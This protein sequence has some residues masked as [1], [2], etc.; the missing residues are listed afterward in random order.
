M[1]NILFLVIAL[2]VIVISGCTSELTDKE[3][4]PSEQGVQEGHIVDISETRILVVSDITREQAF[5][6]TQE[7]LLSNGVGKMAVWYS[8]EDIS[9]YEI[10][11]LVRVKS[12][13]M[14]ES[15]PAQS[16]AIKVQVVEQP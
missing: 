14:L 15:Y 1:R 3:L 12:E 10:G 7:Q 11:Q 6:I 2:I 8:V 9:T 13:Y 5:Q 16:E 4:D